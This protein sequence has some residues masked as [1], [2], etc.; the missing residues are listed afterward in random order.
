M[1]EHVNLDAAA[2]GQR[3]H[4]VHIGADSISVMNA[5]SGVLPYSEKV[6]NAWPFAKGQPATK[7]W[8]LTGP[9]LTKIETGGG[10]S[11]HVQDDTR[12]KS[13]TLRLTGCCL[14]K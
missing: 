7:T 8:N 3:A 9:A 10:L 5:G 14:S 4:R 1:R 2:I 13:A 6:Y 12:V 11:L